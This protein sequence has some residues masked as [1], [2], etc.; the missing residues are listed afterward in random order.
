M[1]FMN[2][3]DTADLVA[4]F[5]GAPIHVETAEGY[6][7]CAELTDT[8]PTTGDTFVSGVLEVQTLT[9]PAKA[10]AA[11]GDYLVASDQAGLT[12]A[13]ALTKPVAEVQTLTFP[14]KATAANGDYIV[15]ENTIG[16][17]YAVALT[18]P[19]AEV[20]TLTFPTVAG[21]TGGDYIVISD[22]SGN[23][24]AA[25]LNKSGVD[26][27][28]T[29][30][31]YAAIPA[32]RKVNVNIS[33]GTDEASVAALVELALDALTGFTALI[34]TDDSAADGTMLLTSVAKAPVTNPVPHNADDSG[35]GTI[36]GVQT[37]GGVAAQTP[38]GALW[39]AATHK[40]LADISGD[41]TAA[42]VAVSAETAL[43]LLTG[44]TAAITS[45]DSAA[46]GTMTLTSILKAPVVNPVPKSFD[47][48]TAGTITGVQSTGGVAAQ[49]P[50][51][52]IW[53]AV[54]G[55]RKGLADISGDTTAA[56]VAASAETAWNLL[57]G[58]TAAITSNDGAANGT[59]TFTQV[60]RGPVTDPV[61]KSFDDAGA[62]SILGVQ[63][64]A[65]VTSKV[66][67][68]NDTFEIADASDYPVGLKIRLTTSSALPTGVLT[69]TDYYVIPVSATTF[70]VAL[71]LAD[72]LAGTE[73]DITGYGTGTQTIAVQD[74]LTGTLKLQASNNAFA[75][76]TNNELDA[77]AVWVDIPGSSVAV[78]AT[79]NQFW[80]VSDVYYKAVRVVWT[81]TVN[82]GDYVAYIYT[83]SPY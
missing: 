81:R 35:P 8:T 24:W 42:N 53:T 43:N 26:P 1:K 46:N 16:T 78:T 25:A 34:V 2:R 12:Y 41:T 32:G 59:M 71:S 4:S 48:G 58:F 65:G 28:P 29:G 45:D 23:T 64:T 60:I 33:G 79:A 13:I 75:D 20:Q 30:A 3:T 52:P 80:N 57:T 15:V 74:A 55:A 38:T 68:T 14:D 63:S 36:S 70:Q 77:D 56:Q 27:A 37:T 83:K 19:V 44:F 40:G 72:A 22:T 51:G 61:P 39:V 18:K 54:A 17:K 50:T 66:N 73:I 49:T 82:G 69:A 10:A 21:S 31:I 11:N 7:I 76:N 9:Y 5:N 67:L 47:D 6:S 62:G